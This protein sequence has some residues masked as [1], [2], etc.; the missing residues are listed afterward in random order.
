MEFIG[1]EEEL[2]ILER[3]YNRSSS[4][5][6]IYGRRR[7]GKTTLIKQFIKDKKAVYFF[8]GLEPDR[9]N[10]NKF[11]SKIM[12]FTSQ[13]YLSEVRFD[14]WQ[15]I[16]KVFANHNS[17]EKKILVIDE[18]QYLVQSNLA[19]TSI[20]QE[21]WD[22]IL[23][24]NNIMV[25]LCGSHISMMTTAVLNHS[26]PLYGRRTAQIRL[27]PLRFMEFTKAFKVKSFDDMV[28]IFSV[29]GGVPK[30]MEFFC[31]DYSFENNVVENV[32]NKS[33]F[34]YE[35]PMFLLEKEVREPVNYFSILKVIAMGN[36]KLSEIATV[37]EQRTNNLSPYLETLSNLFL[38]EKRLPITE[39]IPEKSR[40]GL[41]YISDNFIELWFKFVYLYKSELELDNINYVLDKIN[42]N[43]IDNHVSFIYEKVCMEIFTNLCRNS[44]FD[45]HISK[46]GSYWNN[47]TQIDV[48]AIDENSKKIFA[49]E[50]KFLGK[51]VNVRVYFDLLDKCEG[52]KEFKEY[53]VILGIFSKSGFD[54][55]LMEISRNNNKL[56]L[57]N[58]EN[59]LI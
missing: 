30:Y 1:R 29:T 22:E 14:S 58:Q 15:S 49:G 20:F 13:N 32:L 3:E 41:Y 16:F 55:R 19:F 17:N 57:I 23:K 6:V 7:V 8:A 31:N 59:I 33:G 53:E 54:K 10:I 36:H 40:K 37:L 39:K 38:L 45:F 48:V 4:F 42:K 18:F 56:I 52:I 51:P 5:V 27:N 44:N 11:A 34:L 9:Q 12:E 24:D 50:C 43:L 28:K 21:V 2:K 47:N 26:S 35:E 25:I 46:I